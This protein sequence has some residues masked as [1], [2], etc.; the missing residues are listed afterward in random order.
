MAG[1]GGMSRSYLSIQKICW[2]WG[3]DRCPFHMLPHAA[4]VWK[5]Q[6][7]R[8]G[9]WAVAQDNLTYTNTDVLTH[10]VQYIPAL[11]PLNHR[12]KFICLCFIC[13]CD[14][15]PGKLHQPSKLNTHTW[16]SKDGEW[17]RAKDGKDSFIIPEIWNSSC[18]SHSHTFKEIFQIILNE[19]VW[20]IYW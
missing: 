5:E 15:L 4:W 17:Q 8:N 7:G 2:R 19:D 13:F 1:G 3:S 11:L 20:D 14:S 16:K 6:E 12:K 9:H 10:T 18:D